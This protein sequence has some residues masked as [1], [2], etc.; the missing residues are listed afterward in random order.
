MTDFFSTLSPTLQALCAT[1]FTWAITAAGA[2]LVFLFKKPNKTLLDAMLG[3]AAGVMTA[4]SF[5]SLLMPAIETA[6]MLE[7]CEWLTVLIGFLGGGVLLFVGDRLMA[8]FERK[9]NALDKRKRSL[10]LIFSITLHNIPEG[11]A[12]GVAFGSAACGLEGATLTAAC[13]LALGIGIQNFP[14]G[15]AVSVPLHRDGASRG[16]SF[17]IGQLSG[18][19]EPIAGVIG[20]VAVTQSRALLPY[21]LS[22]AAGAM[23]YVVVDELIPESQTN[24]RKDIMA[25]FTLIGFSVMMVL[26]VALG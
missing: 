9:N 26:D 17:F 24:D 19:V 16:K 20:A 12:V 7:L 8:Y 13:M 5:W 2:G 25:M 22:F 15:T 14:E 10:M 21:M 18:V 1:L 11:M 6:Q 3:F 4:A 23:I